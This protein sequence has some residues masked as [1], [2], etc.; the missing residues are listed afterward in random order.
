MNRTALVSLS[1]V[2]VASTLAIAV[3]RPGAARAGAAK[4]DAPQI[5]ELIMDG[6]DAGHIM[7]ADRCSNGG[8]SDDAGRAKFIAAMRAD[9]Q[10]KLARTL[11]AAAARFIPQK[12]KDFYEIDLGDWFQTYHL[13]IGCG[14][15]SISFSAPIYLLSKMRNT[16]EVQTKYLVTIDDDVVA[17]RRTFRLRSIT[18]LALRDH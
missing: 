4:A 12:E 2:F 11:V 3:P 9:K 6:H 7:Y 16:H 15:T 8:N 5:G 1:F 18:P 10:S 13:R 14:E 17:D